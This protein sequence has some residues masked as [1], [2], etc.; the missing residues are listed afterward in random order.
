MTVS[1]SKFQDDIAN[2]ADLEKL[3]TEAYAI[4]IKI[5]DL[6]MEEWC[7]NELKG[8]TN[9]SD[10]PEY[11]KISV[12][13]VAD[14]L[15]VKNKPTVVP[16]EMEYLNKRN[17]TNS[18]PSLYKLSNK[19][20]GKYIVFPISSEVNADLGHL[21]FRTGDDYT[22]KHIAGA[23]R[24]LD[25]V[26]AVKDKIIRWGM[27][28]KP[29]EVIDNDDS[30]ESPSVNVTYNNITGNQISDSQIQQETDKSKQKQS[31]WKLKDLL[32]SIFDHLVG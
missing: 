14:G 20:E 25:V 29:E 15:F 28:L 31:H 10:A 18:I 24:L 23:N 9:G 22:F 3:L 4:S 30:I 26:S 16:K 19:N 1:I 8:Y 17:V 12:E 6:K 27:N 13:L 2:N 5:H 21:L 11:R 7:H 32:G